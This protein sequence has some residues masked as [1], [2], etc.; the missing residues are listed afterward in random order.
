MKRVIRI[1]VFETN[2]SSTHSLTIMMLDDYKRW[3]KSKTL[4]LHLDSGKLYSKKEAIAALKT[5]IHDQ[6]SI[7]WNDSEAGTAVDNELY[8]ADFLTAEEYNCKEFHGEYYSGTFVTRNGD[9]VI[10]FGCS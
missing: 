5:E 3:Q 1:G 2:S 10:A 7:D 6:E 4:Y 8:Y 9:K